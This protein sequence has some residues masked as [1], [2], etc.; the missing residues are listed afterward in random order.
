MD[1]AL[2]SGPTNHGHN[3]AFIDSILN[4]GPSL[5]PIAYKLGEQRSG[6]YFRAASDSI[7][8]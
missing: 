8:C 7:A 4:Q 1:A 6:A 2:A 5:F 3:E